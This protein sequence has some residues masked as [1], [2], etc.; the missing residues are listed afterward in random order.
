MSDK[1]LQKMLVTKSKIKKPTSRTKEAIREAAMQLTPEEQLDVIFHSNTDFE[2]EIS[3][4]S[5]LEEGS[6]V[7]NVDE[8]DVLMALALESKE[9]A[10]AADS[11]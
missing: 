2:M 8:D 11:N 7:D 10:P 6:S 5:E 4:S 1:K 9:A 3:S